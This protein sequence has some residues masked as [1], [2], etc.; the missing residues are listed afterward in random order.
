MSTTFSA[1]TGTADE[2]AGSVDPDGRGTGGLGD[3]VFLMVV[4]SVG[5][6]LNSLVAA[7]LLTMPSIDGG[8]RQ[9]RRSAAS[10][11]IHSCLLD[12]VK[13]VYCVPFAVTSLQSVDPTVCDAFS[14]SVYNVMPLHCGRSIIVR[15]HS[16][17][18]VRASTSVRH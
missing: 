7:S 9:H 6:T 16:D 4:A 5:L 1:T 8:Q 12:S 17:A 18:S 13:C 11:V 14:R 10:L 2:A 3:T 15:F